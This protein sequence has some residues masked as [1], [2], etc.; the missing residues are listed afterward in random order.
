MIQKNTVEQFIKFVVVGV[1]STMVNYGLFYILLTYSHL[2]Y[3]IASAIG[4][5]AGVC[6]GFLLNK[7]WT[8]SNDSEAGKYVFKYFILYTVS[9]AVSLL[10][11]KITV[12]KF[13]IDARVANVLS[14]GITTVINFIGTKWMVFKA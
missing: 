1:L 12:E 3:K 8:F 4:F 7:S 14:I 6:A 10:F 2:D 5:I 13:N 9:L 11:L